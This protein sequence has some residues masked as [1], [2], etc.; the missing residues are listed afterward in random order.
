MFMISTF[1]KLSFRKM[2]NDRS[3]SLL[4]ITGLCLA[5]VSCAIIWLYVS[6]ER[7]FDNFRSPDIYRVAF[8]SFKDNVETGNSA[9]V[10]PA[11]G[12]AINND[13]PEVKTT[14]R[15]VH[16]SPFMSDPVMQYGEKKFRESKIYFADEAFLSMFSYEMI[17]GSADKALTM[18]NQ[19][20]LSRSSVEKYFGKE[21]AIG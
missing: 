6:Y 16:T 4:S 2:W 10:D 15:L 8:H 9:Q 17:S 1:V 20:A 21:D 18:A 12:P 11:L 14:A 19:V 3:F 13:I 5:T 7:S